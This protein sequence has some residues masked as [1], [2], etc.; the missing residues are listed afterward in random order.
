VEA[1][2]KIKSGSGDG[3]MIEDYMENF[4]YHPSLEVMMWMM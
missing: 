4:F 2:L 3:E 1:F